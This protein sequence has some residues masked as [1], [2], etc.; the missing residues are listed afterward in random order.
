M[1]FMDNAVK[2]IGLN[3]IYGNQEAEVV[4]DMKDHTGDVLQ[5]ANGLKVEIKV[6]V[7]G[8]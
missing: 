8:K 3:L 7:V 2:M 1:H 6:D 5:D 4:R